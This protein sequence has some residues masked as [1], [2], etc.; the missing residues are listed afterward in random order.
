MSHFFENIIAYGKSARPSLPFLLDIAD[1]AAGNR[2]ALSSPGPL[3]RRLERLYI[4]LCR[5]QEELSRLD[6][7]RARLGAALSIDGY[8]TLEDFAF[9]SIDFT[10]YHAI[11]E[12]DFDKLFPEGLTDF[13]DS[14]FRKNFGLGRSALR[15]IIEKSYE[16]KDGAYRLRQESPL[17]LS[18]MR[19]LETSTAIV[20]LF[21]VTDIGTELQT[22]QA[23]MPPPPHAAAHT[24]APD[25]K[26]LYSLLV[27]SLDNTAF[28]HDN[29]TETKL[30]ISPQGDLSGTFQPGGKPWTQ[31]LIPAEH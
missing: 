21:T 29:G 19:A 23:Q 9:S 2:R 3:K 30:F 25:A 7:K 22:L 18:L 12:K 26:R 15:I 20:P 13:D 31:V 16:K 14:F 8:K 17:I 5:L 4:R 11:V 10:R 24:S 6:L 28:I 27:H 1:V